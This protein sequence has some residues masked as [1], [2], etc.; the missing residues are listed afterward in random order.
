MVAVAV[1]I[2][3]QHQGI[4]DYLKEENRV[5]RE[6]LGP[7]KPRY[8]DLQ[9]RRLAAKG[10]LLGRQVPRAVATLMTPYGSQTPTAPFSRV[11]RQLPKSACPNGGCCGFAS[12]YSSAGLLRMCFGTLRDAYICKTLKSSE[13]Q[14]LLHDMVAPW[15]EKVLQRAQFWPKPEEIRI[16]LERWKNSR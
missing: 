1:W 13:L 7:K 9:R 15:V 5:L 6:Q 16:L 14:R 2:S 8:T 10:R 3:R 12:I 11:T 4:I